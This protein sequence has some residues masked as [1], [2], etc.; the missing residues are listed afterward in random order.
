MGRNN[1]QDA[2]NKLLEI[3][4]LKGY[5]TFDI[6][7]SCAD[8]YD[9][10]LPDFDWLSNEATSRNVIIY[11][12]EPATREI[13]EDE[14]VDDYA[15]VDYEATYSEVVTLCPAMEDFVCQIRSIRPPQF[16]E[17]SR[18]KYLVKEGN[19][20]ARERMIEMHLRLALRIG[21]QRAKAYDADVEETVGD[22]CVGLINAVDRYDPDTSGP[23]SSYASLWILQNVSREQPTQNPLMYFPVHKR[24]DYFT[25]Y[26]ILKAADCRG[27]GALERDPEAVQLICERL[28][29]K[30][31]Q[32]ADLW[33][34][35][36]PFESLDAIFS[37]AEY[38]E[39][40]MRSAFG[41]DPLPLDEAVFEKIDH[42]AMRQQ[43]HSVLST[44]TPREEMV[45]K[46]RYGIEDA[47][48]H[49]L[50]EVGQE[51]KVTRERIRQIEKKAL[52]KLNHPSRTRKLKSFWFSDTADST[53]KAKQS[54]ETK[55][56][57]S[58]GTGKTRKQVEPQDDERDEHIEE[59]TTLDVEH[60]NLYTSD[61]AENEES[62]AEEER[63]LE[64]VQP[65]RD[66]G[67]VNAT[68]FSAWLKEEGI[69]KAVSK[70]ILA[71]VNKADAYAYACG[72]PAAC[73]YGIKSL[74]DARMAIYA[75]NA[76]R[77]FE[78]QEKAAAIN[79]RKFG[80]HYMNFVKRMLSKNP[81]VLSTQTM[82]NASNETP[83]DETKPERSSSQNCPV[84]PP[85][86]QNATVKAGDALL[87][88]IKDEGLSYRDNRDKGGCLWVFG[89][90][91]ITQ[92]IQKLEKKTG[93]GFRYKKDG[94]ASTRRPAWW[95]KGIA[96]RGGDVDDNV[97][98]L[99]EYERSSKPS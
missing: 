24:D 23:F 91:E 78:I 45:I 25:V 19:T 21:F 4:A 62:E 31:D 48:E 65:W 75:M 6:I 32:L 95:T 60:E 34:A 87:C 61:T 27:Y 94:P 79:L 63:A 30:P 7:M 84:V 26:P 85:M 80:V 51:F 29:Y 1:R 14:V 40:K 92:K 76:N 46:L 43:V 18:L 22:A 42:A 83:E 96:L 66:L 88:A 74:K 90:T 15:Q 58:N 35:L 8:D 93:V 13:D 10:S 47:E 12:E 55:A 73:L 49:T 37:T 59:A 39:S 44:L 52:R 17:T 89:G 36:I 28:G 77:E 68:L 53:K 50:E 97:Y 81:L 41:R 54:S 86:V 67:M 82:V 5:V 71:A 64:E 16:K 9:L 56:N 70:A 98:V 3:A 20:H 2:L 72:I 33:K 11:D 99:P 38:D 69:D 57:K